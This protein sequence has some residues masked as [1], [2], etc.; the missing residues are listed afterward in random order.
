MDVALPKQ[1]TRH[2]M[3]SLL[4]AVIDNDLGPKDSRINFDFCKLQFIEP[5]GI[6]ILSNLFEW[7]VRR[8][9]HVTIECPDGNETGNGHVIQFLDDSRFFLR[10]IGHTITSSPS[11]RQT[12]I[13]LQLIP[14]SNSYQWLRTDFAFWLS[15]QL[16]VTVQSLD[17]IIMCFGEIFNNINDHAQENTGCIFAQHFPNLKEIKIAISDFGVGIPNNIRQIEQSLQDHFAIAR[18]TEEGITSRTSPRNLGAGLHTLIENVVKDI[19]GAVH[20]HSNY[21]ILSC[22]LGN[23]EVYKTPVLMNKFYPGTFI[24]V[25][26]R[27]DHIENITDY[28]E[29]FEW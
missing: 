29:E 25:V 15:N 5:A 22:A 11:V 18:A 8:G 10:Y 4:G 27:T 19:G 16:G 7:L 17:N 23:N 12:T 13:P 26:L 28:E 6:T 2:T 24:E 3:Y 14:Y 1:F 21:G 20:I 9:V